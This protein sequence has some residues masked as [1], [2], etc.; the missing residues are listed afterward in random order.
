M[1]KP[2]FTNDQFQ[3]FVLE[4]LKAA[5]PFEEYSEFIKEFEDF[6][7]EGLWADMYDALENHINFNDLE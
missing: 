5:H 4:I 7:N 3:E 6:N 1:N 2:T